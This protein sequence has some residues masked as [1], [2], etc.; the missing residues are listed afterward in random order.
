MPAGLVGMNPLSLRSWVLGATAVVVASLSSVSAVRAH[1]GQAHGDGF[2]SV[3]FP[4]SCSAQAQSRFN[5]A[6]AMLHTFSPAARGAFLAIAESEP[7][8][9]MAYWGV[10]M[11]AR[12][13]PL[14]GALPAEAVQ[15]GREAIRKARA[16]PA[17][18]ERERDWIEAVGAYFDGPPDRD[19]LSRVQAYE[20]AMEGLRDRYPEDDEIEIFYAL[21]L[22]EAAD[23]SDMTYRRQIQAAT[24]LERLE[25]KLLEHP[26]IPHYLIHSYDYAPIAIKG[27]PA[28]RRLARIAPAS[29][30]ALHM[31]SHIFSM[32]GLWQDAIQADRAADD[33]IKATATGSGKA[34]PAT[35]PGRYHSL[36]F[37]MNAHL[38]LAQD[39]EA[40]RILD[41]RNSLETFPPGFIYS[42]HVAFAAIPVRYALERGDW[43]AASRL[44]ISRTPFAQAAAVTEFARGLGAA[45]TGDAPAARVALGQLANLRTQLA[46]AG[47]AYWARQIDI[48]AKAVEAWALLAERRRREAVPLMRQ[49]AELEG[50]SEKHVALENR[51]VPMRELL[52]EMLLEVRQP[53]LALSEFGASLQTSPNRYRSFAGA[54]KA[55]ERMGSDA[56]PIARRYYEALLRLAADADSERPEMEAARRFLGERTLAQGH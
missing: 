48:Y 9:T 24:I 23:L 33:Y 1:D 56:A 44:E 39:R 53:A 28:A 20:A 42:G 26:G 21:A 34:E 18:T 52:G 54:A 51:L 40:K 14:V 10:A 30:H 49:A 5:R 3:D 6:V 36:D 2:G 38:Q 8:C 37:L 19:R 29:A 15:R 32:L 41:E 55:A 4:V 7:D 50:A 47:E 35:L 11:A 25:G 12:G 43:L 27:E 45:R 13:N 16:T 17:K 22:N 46:D 31:P